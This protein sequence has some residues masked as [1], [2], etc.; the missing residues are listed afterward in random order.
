MANRYVLRRLVVRTAALLADRGG[1]QAD[2]RQALGLVT[3]EDGWIGD[4]YGKETAEG[5]RA[6]QVFGDAGLTLDPTYTAKAGAALLGHR[7]TAN[8][9]PTLLNMAGSSAERFG[10]ADP[11]LQ[12]LDQTGPL[13]ELLA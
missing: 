10:M 11:N 3:L 1:P 6:Q 7:T 13:T 9:S 2:V 5:E 12:D 4:G 8:L